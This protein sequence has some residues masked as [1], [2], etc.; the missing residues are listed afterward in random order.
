MVDKNY[1]EKELQEWKEWAEE[2]DRNTENK[3][4]EDGDPI[5]NEFD[6]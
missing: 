1:S 2:F 5:K 6:N 3:H 4:D